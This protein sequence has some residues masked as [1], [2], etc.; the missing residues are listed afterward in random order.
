MIVWCRVPETPHPVKGELFA[1]PGTKNRPAFIHTVY[2]SEN[3]EPSVLLVIPGS[4][5]HPSN[6]NSYSWDYWC[7]ETHAEFEATGLCQNTRFKTNDIVKI[8]FTS[9][10]FDECAPIR[11]SKLRKENSIMSQSAPIKSQIHKAL[12]IW[13]TEIKR[14]KNRS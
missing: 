8:P 13:I 5:K 4:T 2:P 6:G 3:N 7:H 14:R 9:L 11:G 12:E 1:P 10:Y